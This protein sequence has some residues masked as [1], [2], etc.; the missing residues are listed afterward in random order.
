MN[1]SSQR[2]KLNK[3]CVAF[4]LHFCILYLCVFCS[5]CKALTTIQRSAQN[6]IFRSYDS[7]LSVPS[8]V[9]SCFYL[10]ISSPAPTFSLFVYGCVILCMRGR[11]GERE[12]L[13]W[14]CIDRHDYICLLPAIVL[15]SSVPTRH[16]SQTFASFTVKMLIVTANHRGF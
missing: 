1:C 11:E 7:L 2:M 4:H 15:V 9:D 12:I 3:C 8:T 6:S 5:V 10:H 14:C 13:F 16:L